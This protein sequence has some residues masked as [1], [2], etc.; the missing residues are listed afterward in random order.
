MSELTHRIDEATGK[1]SKVEDLFSPALVS[2][3][4]K[5]RECSGASIKSDEYISGALDISWR[6]A[7]YEVL[8][9]AK[10]LR[11]SQNWQNSEI[12]Y[13]KSHLIQSFGFYQYLVLSLQTGLDFDHETAYGYVF[14]GTYIYI[15]EFLKI[16]N[17]I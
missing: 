1:C 5:L 10:R 15:F 7:S 13:F 4:L 12:A 11:K 2:L 9:V 17:L 6:K 3:R 16:N 8:H 14:E